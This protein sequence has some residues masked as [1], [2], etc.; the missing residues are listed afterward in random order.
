MPDFFALR[1]QVKHYE[2]GS[3]RWIPRLLGAANSDGR[4]WAEFWMG[5]HSAS[6]SRITLD[7]EEISLGEFVARDPLYCLGRRAAQKY[8]ALPFLFKLLAAEKP[9]SIQ[10]HP[11]LAQ[12]RKGFERE[13]AAG[14]APD[15]PVR[16]YK[17]PNHKPEIICALTPFT[18]M[19]G[20]RAPAETRR[21]LTDFLAGAPPLLRKSFAPSLAAL[22]DDHTAAALRK[23][24]AALFDLSAP[25]REEL[26][27]YILSSGRREGSP[28]WRLMRR[29]AGLYPG[30]PALVAPL[31][32]NVFHLRPGE[33]IFLRAGI[34]HA[35]IHGFG[36]ELMANS[37]NVLRGGLTSKHVDVPELMGVLDFS[38][39]KPEIL[40]PGEPPPACFRYPAPCDEFSLSV[41][42]GGGE[43]AAFAEAGPAICVVVDG[44]LRVTSESG[45]GAVFRAGAS[46]FVP[47]GADGKSPLVFG[48]NYTL[49]TAAIPP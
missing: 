42:R 10:A 22:D 32:L 15:A 26:T 17:D 31:Y 28:E 5:S 23:F 48:G 36:V 8:G 11:N 9:L 37:D 7:G 25:A 18:G 19:C 49:Y 24:L 39:L 20:F 3:P 14:L 13:N 44:V 30:D 12:A 41:M 34:L 1:G 16:S 27:R 46:F 29:F 43:D 33:A 6:P 35:Y 47:A 38:P 21:R 40:A 4:P 45:A 2:W